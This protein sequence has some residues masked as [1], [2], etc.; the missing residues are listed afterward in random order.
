MNSASKVTETIFGPFKYIYLE[1]KGS[2]EQQETL[3]PDLEEAIAKKN[4]FK[5]FKLAVISYD[6][7]EFFVQKDLRWT[8]GIIVESADAESET[9]SFLKDYPAYS[10]V[11][12]PKCK[13]V[14]HIYKSK[15]DLSDFEEN[16][17]KCYKE[18]KEYVMKLDFCKDDKTGCIEIGYPDLTFEVFLPYGQPEA[19]KYYLTKNPKPAKI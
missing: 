19:S 1:H 15:E 6:D 13:A 17:K 8:L 16:M 2:H 4:Y 9:K 18:F 7:P 10:Q 3:C 5:S 14:K 12:L 11:D